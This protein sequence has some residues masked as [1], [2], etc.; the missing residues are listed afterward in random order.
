MG[1]VF[2]VLIYV[3][4]IIAIISKIKKKAQNKDSGAGQK[5]AAPVSA[6]MRVPVNPPVKTPV[7]RRTNSG[8]NKH[9]AREKTNIREWEDRR[10]DWLARQM[11]DERQAQRRMSE[12]FQLK[13]EHRYNCDAEMLKQ[14]HESRCDAGGIDN[15]KA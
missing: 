10:N 8:V 12:M 4:A 14:F 5:P 15:A 13:M 11:D 7:R 3:F 9:M 1:S 2:A 6:P